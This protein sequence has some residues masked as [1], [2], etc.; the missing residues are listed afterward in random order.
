MDVG[1]LKCYAK[2]PE[3]ATKNFTTERMICWA[4]ALTDFGFQL[5]NLY[6]EEARMPL[7]SKQHC[8]QHTGFICSS[9]PLS[10][11]FGCAKIGVIQ[12]HDIG[13]DAIF[14]SLLY[15]PA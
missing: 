3:S 1:P 14:V 2:R 13:K 11:G 15:R 4:T 10:I 8:C 12:F 5:E 7:F 9:A 6:F